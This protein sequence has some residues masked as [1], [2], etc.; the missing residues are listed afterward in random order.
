MATNKA[1]GIPSAALAVM[2]ASKF[3]ISDNLPIPASRGGFGKSEG[4]E[5]YPF[6]DLAMNASFLVPVETPA[7]ITDAGERAAAFKEAARKLAN[8]MSNRIRTFKKHNDGTNFVART[9]DDDTYGHG[10]RVW[11]VE[12]KAAPTPPPVPAQ[13]SA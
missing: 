9:V 4:A 10:V 1:P 12:P 6:G 5:I 3:A 13:P 7:S 11:R 2:A 8:S